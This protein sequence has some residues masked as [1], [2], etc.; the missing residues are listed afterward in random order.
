MKIL[1][2]P[3]TGAV[4]HALIIDCISAVIGTAPS[5]IVSCVALKADSAVVGSTV[6]HP[7]RC[8]SDRL[9]KIIKVTAP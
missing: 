3:I 6:S 5:A 2:P 1:E 8:I 4:F 7:G 9:Q